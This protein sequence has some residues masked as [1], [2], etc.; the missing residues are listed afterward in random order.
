V[1][2]VAFVAAA[3]GERQE[4]V[5]VLSPT[6]PVHVRSATGTVVT[7][8]K[9]PRR[10]VALDPGSAQLLDRL[11]AGSRLVGAPAGVPLQ[12]SHPRRVT[13]LNDAVDVQAV[14][15]L[16][17]D[18]IVA[19]TEND[20]VDLD[21]ASQ[22]SGAALFVQPDASV[23]LLEQGT[24]ELG[25]LVGAPVR[26]REVV[27][28]MQSGIAQVERR[29]T[30]TRPVSVF[31]DTG[32]FVPAPADT[33]LGDLVR[34]AGGKSVAGANPGQEPYD[35]HRIARLDPRF[36]LLTSAAGV[37][38]KHLEK[39]PATRAIPAVRAGRVAVLPSALVQRA[40]PNVAAGLA[41]IAHTL[42]PDAFH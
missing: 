28:S 34:L 33:L 14:V 6:Y 3:C 26:A 16:H 25:T 22:G 32:F 40:G 13:G 2:A 41:A 37:S 12:A 38:P 15:G 8:G 39:D 29:L 5:G 18:L 10:I 30:S 11:G 21:R 23:H 17:P 9:L 7:L 35:P 4:P 27:A 31:V 24:V 42:H 1:L 20:P 36:Y 19:T